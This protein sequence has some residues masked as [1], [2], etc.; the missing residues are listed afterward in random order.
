MTKIKKRDELT[1][2]AINWINSSTGKQKLQNAYKRAKKTTD[3]LDEAR[4]VDPES[5]RRPITR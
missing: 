1:S 3:Y 5:L 4:Q 2:K